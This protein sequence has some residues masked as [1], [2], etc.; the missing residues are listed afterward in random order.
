MKRYILHTAIL[1]AA[2][3]AL[4]SCIKDEMDPES[5]ITVSQTK[6]NDFDRWL[7]TN[8]LLPYNIDFKYRY[9]MNESDMDFFTIPADYEYSIVMAHLVKYLCVETYDEVAGITFTRTYFPKMFF[10]TG[11]W[12]Y[13]NNGTIILGTAEGGKKIFLAGVNLL[14]QTLEKGYGEFYGDPMESLNHYFI[15]TIH[16]EFTH[17]M[18]QTVDYP[19]EF[20]MITG[21]S[22]VADSW[23]DSPYVNE[24]LQN[25]FITAYA[26]KEDTEDFAEMLSEYIT[27]S[28]AW[29]D[30]Q[31][32]KAGENGAL[33]NAKLDIVKTYMLESFNIDVDQLRATVLRRQDDVF[34]GQVDLHSVTIQ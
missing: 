6:K 28:Q 17:I 1:A 20:A 31:I 11:E 30:E 9:E 4:C 32:G 15:K 7:E 24:F 29:W 3:A 27:H 5:V 21:K 34:S 19:V 2:L 16:H 25:G 12:E 13:Q 14:Q 18:N 22:Y 26:Q 10:L 33:I 23:S 8:F